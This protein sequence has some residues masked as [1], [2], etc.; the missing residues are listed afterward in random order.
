VLEA[1]WI[2]AAGML[3]SGDK[4]NREYV[5]LD[6]EIA[7]SAMRIYYSCS[8]I[9]RQRAGWLISIARRSSKPLL[10]LLKENYPASSM[11]GRVTDRREYSII[12]RQ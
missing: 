7:G 11:I 2:C 9:R 1:R 5:G 6:I 8:S 10:E 12:V 3:T 4:T